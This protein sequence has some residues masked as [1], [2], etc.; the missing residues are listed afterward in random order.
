MKKY[1]FALAMILCLSTAAFAGGPYF[2]FGSLDVNSFAGVTSGHFG[3]GASYSVANNQSQSGF[4]AGM[5]CQGGVGMEAATYA[6]SVGYTAGVA[7]G[8]GFTSGMQTGFAYS[9]F[10]W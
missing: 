9:G 5:G 2:G 1:L 8:Y 6:N 10:K 7:F 3:S 4:C